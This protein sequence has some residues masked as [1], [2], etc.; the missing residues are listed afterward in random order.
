MA[1][2]APALRLDRGIV[3]IV[4]VDIDTLRADHLGCYGYG[5]GTTPNLDRLAE[6]SVLFEG[7]YASDVPC[8]PSRTALFSGRFGTSTGVVGHGGTAADPIVEGASRGF[9]SMLGKTAWPALMRKQ[10]LRTASIS[11]FAARHSAHHFCAGLDELISP[12]KLGL[13]NADEVCALAIDW[14]ERHRDLPA[15]FLHVHLW[16]PHTPYRAP[17][18]FGDPFAATALPSWLSDTVRAR[19]FAGAGPHSAQ[20]A[21]G[22]DADYPYGVYPRQPRAMPSLREV[23]AMF[24]GYDTGVR[25]ADEQ[26]GKL[27]AHLDDQT[28]IVVSADHGEALGELNVYG[29]HHTADEHTARV[30]CLLRWPGLGP[31]R[32]QSLCYQVDVAATVIDLLGGSVPPTWDGSSLAPALR[33]GTDAGRRELVITQGA[34]TCQRALRWDRWLAISTLHDGYHDY[35]P[36]MLFD[37]QNDPH[38]QHNLADDQPKLIEHAASKIEAWRIE[39]VRSNPQAKDPLLTVLAEGGPWHTRGRLAAYLQRLRATGREQLADRLAT[40]HAGELGA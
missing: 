19:H 5:R 28:A 15:W 29:D 9:F 23:R 34:W 32:F 21:V 38:E 6:H 36:W 33:S 17:E 16:D 40:A 14:L 22:F 12:G 25:F 27:F 24:D 26:L 8:L 7:C 31:R 4:Y 35:P 1:T 10:G 13:E 39:A 3:R 2:A 18:S 37:L 11:S 20:E 30:P